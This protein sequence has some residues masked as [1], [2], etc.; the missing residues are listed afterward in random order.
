MGTAFINK[1]L[2]NNKNINPFMNLNL[3]VLTVSVPVRFP[4][5]NHGRMERKQPDGAK[6]ER[7]QEKKAL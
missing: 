4:S 7:A 5:S 2:N 1:I 6:R 3:L